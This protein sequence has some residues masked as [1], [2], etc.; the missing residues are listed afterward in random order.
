[1]GSSQAMRA[2]ER[3]GKGDAEGKEVAGLTQDFFAR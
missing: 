1:M 2:A 3:V